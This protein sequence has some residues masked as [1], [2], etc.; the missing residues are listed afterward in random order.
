LV[1]SAFARVRAIDGMASLM[2]CT[3][4]VGQPNTTLFVVNF[5]PDRTR[6]RDLEDAFGY[7]TPAPLS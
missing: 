7:A 2:R 4:L 3:G 5:D 6:P 1:M